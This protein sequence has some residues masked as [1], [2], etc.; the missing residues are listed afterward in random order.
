MN[1]LRFVMLTCGFYVA[2]AVGM[3]VLASLYLTSHP[4][5][6]TKRSRIG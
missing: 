4:S 6:L 3:Q 5:S 2:T 1:D